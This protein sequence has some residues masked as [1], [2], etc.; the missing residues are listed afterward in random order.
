MFLKE[1]I[2]M[3]VFIVCGILGPPLYMAT[4]IQEY[5]GKNEA[6]RKGTGE[7]N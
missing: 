3:G 5:N 4:N 6:R 1:L 7:G 2:V